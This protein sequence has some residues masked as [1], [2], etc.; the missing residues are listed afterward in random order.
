[1]FGHPPKEKKWVSWTIFSLWGIILF[2]TIPFARF[3]QK[4]LTSLFG[5]QVYTMGVIAWVAAGL[6]L[7]VIYFYRNR[8]ASY[9]NYLW[10]TGVAGIYVWCILKLNL[11]P[12]ETIHFVQYGLLGIFAY[13]ALSHTVRDVSIYFAAAIICGIVGIADEFVQWIVPRRFW[14]WHDIW[15]NFLSSLLVQ[16]AIALGI[17]PTIIS[18]RSGPLSILRLSRLA[19][20]ALILLGASMLNTPEKIVWYADR[21]PFLS[22]LKENNTVMV[23]YG[24]LYQDPEIGIFQSRY[25]PERL[26]QIDITRGEEAAR[27]LDRYRDRA[28]YHLFLKRYTP[29]TDPFVHEAR[30]HLFRRDMHFDMAEADTG[31]VKKL[32]WHCTVAYLENRIMEKYFTDTLDHSSYGWSAETVSSLKKSLLNDHIYESRV[33]KN[34]F[35]RITERQVIGFFVCILTGLFVLDFYTRRRTHG[36]A[37]E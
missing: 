10:L 13:R 35:T 31:D 24:F 20:A 29:I 9:G 2:V 17:K 30:V 26:R 3:L 5:H 32:A 34:L 25:P 16:A 14:G 12:V 28:G 22:F 7:S 21:I 36:T 18:G 8:T 33:S 1:M 37:G 15:I 19:M 11:V 23:E 4:S 27:I 6:I